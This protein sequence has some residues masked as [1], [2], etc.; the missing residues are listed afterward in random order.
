[1]PD[2]DVSQPVSE[3][4]PIFEAVIVPHRSLTRRGAAAVV[5]LLGF[6]IALIVARFW[7]AGAWP[8]VAFSLLEIP[9]L[10]VLLLLNLRAGQASEMILLTQAQVSVTRRDPS[11][12]QTGF[13]MPAAW[14]RVDCDAEGTHL[15][16][17]THGNQQ[18]VGA[19]LHAEDKQSLAR[20][21]NAALRDLR[22]PRFTNRQ[23]E[24]R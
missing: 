19:F 13:V 24:D 1:M 5:S 6:L 14:L 21:L 4:A 11:G 18:E 15:F 22:N 2:P 3:A 23:L 7:L 17:R 10:I 9:L 8:V 20:A 12:R 16:L